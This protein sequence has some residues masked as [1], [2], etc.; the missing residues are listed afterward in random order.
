MGQK[1]PD[2]DALPMCSR[3]HRTGK[4]SH[5]DLPK[6]FWIHWGLDRHK[7]VAKHRELFQLE[8]GKL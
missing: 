8:R 3:L 7:L 5:H 2:E 1:G 6:T 4:Y